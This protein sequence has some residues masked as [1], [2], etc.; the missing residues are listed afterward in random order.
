M[1]DSLGAWKQKMYRYTEGFFFSKQ[2]GGPEFPAE[3]LF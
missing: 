1:L 2:N 3:L